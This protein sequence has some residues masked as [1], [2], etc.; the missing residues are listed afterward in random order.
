MTRQTLKSSDCTPCTPFRLV[1]S[2][3]FHAFVRELDPRYALPTRQTLSD[4]LVPGLHH[5]LRTDVQ[6]QLQQSASQALTTDMWTSVNQQAF[7]GVTAHLLMEDLTAISKCLAI[8]P[9]PDIAVLD[10]PERTGD[11]TPTAVVCPPTVCVPG[12]SR[13]NILSVALQVPH[14]TLTSSS[15]STSHVAMHIGTRKVFYGLKVMSFSLH[16]PLAVRGTLRT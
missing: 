16:Q 4:K 15:T 12:I 6:S 7:M 1:D 2:P 10:L 3:A 9:A 13:E 8:K 14:V 5:K 11:V